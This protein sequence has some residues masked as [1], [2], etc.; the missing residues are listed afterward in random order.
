MIL[1][2]FKYLSIIVSA[3]AVKQDSININQ[4]YNSIKNKKTYN[5]Y[6][7]K[8]YRK[9]IVQLILKNNNKEYQR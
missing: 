1:I 7:K 5:V 8:D 3:I 4:K 6:Y 2:L 9:K